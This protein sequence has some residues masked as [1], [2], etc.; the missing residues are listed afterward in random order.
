[1]NKKTFY[2]GLA[3]LALMSV[4]ITSCE[5]DDEPL[6][7]SIDDLTDRVDDLETRI[8]QTNSNLAALQQIVNALQNSVTITSVEP[9]TNGYKINFSDGQTATITNGVD[10]TDAP[11]ISVEL[12]ADGKYYWTLDG[13]PLMADGKPVCASGV[14]GE[15]AIAP[16]IRINPTT[17]EWEVSTD[18]GTTWTSTGFKAEGSDGDS[19]FSEIITTNPA[20]V[21]FKLADGTE[22]NVPRYDATAPKFVI[23]GLEGF[24]RIPYGESKTYSVTT[25]NVADWTISKPDGWRVSFDGNKL[26][27]SAPAADNK[28]AEETGAIGIVVTSA[29]NKSMIVKFNVGVYE[30]RVLTFEDADAK[31]SSYELDYCGMTIST[32]S[33]LIDEQEYGGP[34][35]YGDYASTKY[36]WTDEGNTMLSHTFPNSYGSYCYWGGGHAIS[37]YCGTDLSLGDFMHQLEV[38][39]TGGHNGSANFAM[40]YGYKDNSGYTDSQ[41]LP[42]LEFSDGVARVIDH[43]WIMNSVYAMNCYI[44]GNSLTA[45]IG[46][47]DWVKLVATGYDSTGAKTGEVEFYTC[48]GPDNIV[49]DWTKWDM[50]GLGK[51]VRVEFNILGSSDNGYGFSQPAYFAYD[52]VAVRF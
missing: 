44:D 18:G 39:G 43:M 27:V 49:M 45:Q 9:I 25:E 22:F 5:Y 20:Y 11:V 42:S 24:Q 23:D 33:D 6:W 4:S 50:T 8:G 7:Q 38:Y 2:C 17:K 16:Q 48:N 40:H 46:P 52:D 41:V 28:Y 36:T 12:G 29:D 47:D 13:E 10:G 51:V 34:L 19:L 35:L 14:D 37:N 32:W 1:M 30:M 15:S 31:F 21:T 3:A 26:T